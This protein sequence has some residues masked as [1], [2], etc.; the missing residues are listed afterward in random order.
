MP[1][2]ACCFRNTAAT[3]SLQSA[4]A[5]EPNAKTT[6]KAAIRLRIGISSSRIG[7]VP[8]QFV[9]R[10]SLAEIVQFLVTG[11]WAAPSVAPSP[12]QKPIGSSHA[13]HLNVGSQFKPG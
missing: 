11:P 2:K 3:S 8:I 1:G 13:N 12:R 9:L 6:A 10:F 7:V 5:L 4:N